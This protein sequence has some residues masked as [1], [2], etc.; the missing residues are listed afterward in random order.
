MTI[1]TITPTFYH[2]IN[3]TGQVVGFATAVELAWAKADAYME[4]LLCQK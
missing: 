2:V 1:K 4:S 3:P